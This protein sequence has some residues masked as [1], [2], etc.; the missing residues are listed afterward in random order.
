M[1]CRRKTRAWSLA[2]CAS[3][4]LAFSAS[5]AT[6]ADQF[7][8]AADGAS[9]ECAVSARELTR[10]ALVDDQFASVSKI[11]TGTPYNDFAVTNEP[12]RGDIY[13]SVPETYAARSISF[14]ATTKKGFVYKVACQVQP[15][16]AVQVFITNPAIAKNQASG[17]E[18]E[19]PLETSAVRLIQAMANDRTVDGFEVRQSSGLPARVGDLEIQL[20]AD[21]RGGA[22]AGK[23]I[24]LANR[25][26][27]PLTLAEADLASS[28]TLA[29]SIG[30]PTLKLGE[31]T[32]AFIVGANGGLGH[33]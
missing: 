27:K 3:T 23:V 33:D 15:L 12:L 21:Y 16:P 29:I 19:T 11:S 18:S 20:I 28:Q 6:A 31:S 14:F 30:Q 5:G 9:I 10:F 2:L 17:W 7:K 8:Q 13:V 32:V 1:A 22:L 4:M 24:R 26:R 25:G